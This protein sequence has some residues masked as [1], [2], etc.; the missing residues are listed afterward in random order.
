MVFRTAGA[1]VTVLIGAGSH[2]LAQ[3]YPPPQAYPR[4]PPPATVKCR[5]VA[6]SQSARGAAGSATAGRSGTSL[7]A[8]AYRPI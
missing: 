3:Y 6:A 7:S 8:R 1:V 2:A 5:R 4:Q